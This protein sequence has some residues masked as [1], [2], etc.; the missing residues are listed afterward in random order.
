MSEFICAQRFL[1]EQDLVNAVRAQYS[2]M[3]QGKVKA[4]AAE[5]AA[6]KAL[7]RHLKTHGCKGKP[8]LKDPRNS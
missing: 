6:V 1:L 3:P 7:E 4:R 5:R 8:L 2:A